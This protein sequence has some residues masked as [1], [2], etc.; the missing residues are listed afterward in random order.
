MD[1]THWVHGL[2]RLDQKKMY[3]V[4]CTTAQTKYVKNVK[5]MLFGY[6]G[7]ILQAQHFFLSFIIYLWFYLIHSH[8]VIF[9][10][11]KWSWRYWA[12][13]RVK[14]LTIRFFKLILLSDISKV[15]L[16]PAF[17]TII[18][19]SSKGQIPTNANI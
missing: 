6:F 18:V 15:N 2:S 11:M 8:H 9:I 5:N 13:Q 16:K 7:C 14:I 17:R 4:T 3:H 19:L 12:L 10:A 1:G